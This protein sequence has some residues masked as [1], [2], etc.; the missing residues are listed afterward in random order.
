MDFAVTS[1]YL[2]PKVTMDAMKKATAMFFIVSHAMSSN[3][4]HSTWLKNPARDVALQKLAKMKALIG[5]P[6]QTLNKRFVNEYYASFPDMAPTDR[7]LDTWLKARSA[8]ARHKWV[9]QTHVFFN[10]SRATAYYVHE[11][12]IVV[13]PAGALQPVFFYNDGNPALNYGSLG[14]AGRS[15]H[16]VSSLDDIVDSENIGDLVGAATAYQA[17]RNLPSDHQS[18]TL[19]GLNLTA[20]QLYFVGRCMTLCK[21]DS[22]KSSGRYASPRA[23]CNVPAMNM[24]AFSSAFG[25]RIAAPMNPYSKCSFWM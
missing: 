9:D 25:C 23:R 19:P 3:L 17:L 14:D 22:R 18:Q 13:A 21:R 24:A 11:G 20:E 6:D 16:K 10:M 7:F 2:R 4:R 15:V 8:R 5:S 12:N 1:R